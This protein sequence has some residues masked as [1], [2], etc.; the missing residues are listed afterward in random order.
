MEPKK[1][2]GYV[3]LDAAE[4]RRYGQRMASER[5]NS[6][7]KEEFGG[8]FFDPRTSCDAEMPPQKRCASPATTE[9]KTS[10]SD[11]ENQ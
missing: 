11:L 8:G 10:P 3:P 5:V 9:P 7:L 1:W 4:R 6:R 2:A